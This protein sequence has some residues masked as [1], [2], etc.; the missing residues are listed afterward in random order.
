[1]KE[2]APHLGWWE[3]PSEPWHWE[4]GYKPQSKVAND[5]N[6]GEDSLQAGE[7]NDATYEAGD[8]SGGDP[9]A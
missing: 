7:A 3:L 2:N 1:M 5:E 4:Y 8:L 6:G 9:N